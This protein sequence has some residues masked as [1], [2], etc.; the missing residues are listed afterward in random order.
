MERQ[1]EKV[2][3]T[4]LRAP[5]AFA[6]CERFR[7]RRRSRR[8]LSRR[9]SRERSSD[10]SLSCSRRPD[11]P[12]TPSPERPAA[13]GI[14]ARRPALSPTARPPRPRCLGGPRR[15]ADFRSFFAELPV[16]PG[17]GCA[18]I[19]EILPGEHFEN[20][21]TQVPDIERGGE[22]RAEDAPPAKCIRGCHRSRP[23]AAD[24]PRRPGQPDARLR[25]AR[26]KGCYRASHPCGCN[27]NDAGDRGRAR[28]AG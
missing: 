1:V 13:T 10:R 4:F 17:R 24:L 21:A 19:E 2:V 8:V 25:S 15:R 7:A 22:R 9:I 11:G 23:G 12:E 27:R 3:R 18:W 16:F 20:G 14:F 5:S 26:S 28:F 6:A